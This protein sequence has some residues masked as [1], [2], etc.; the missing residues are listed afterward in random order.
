MPQHAHRAALHRQI[1]LVIVKAIQVR[2]CPAG[3]YKEERRLWNH[4][5]MSIQACMYICV[6]VS[7]RGYVC[8]ATQA[9]VVVLVLRCVHAVMQKRQCTCACLRAFVYTHP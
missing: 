9:F 3:L 5:Q 1:K 8:I 6:P 7:V 2:A 4:P